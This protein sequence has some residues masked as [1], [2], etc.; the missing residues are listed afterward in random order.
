MSKARVLV[1]DDK[2]NFTKLFRRLLPE[3]RFAYEEPSV[4]PTGTVA[5]VARQEVENI[6][7]T[8]EQIDPK[9]L[10][11]FVDASGIPTPLPPTDPGPPADPGPLEEAAA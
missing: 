4:D 10:R 5:K 2:E 7:R 8:I 11:R 9:Q 6:N 1:C 3:D